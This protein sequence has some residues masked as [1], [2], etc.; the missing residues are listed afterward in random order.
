MAWTQPQ[1]GPQPHAGAALRG[2]VR[3][4]TAVHGAAHAPTQPSGTRLTISPWEASDGSPQGPVV[5]GSVCHTDTICPV[6]K[7]RGQLKL[8]WHSW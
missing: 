8:R 6:L 5:P 4:R 7:S 2:R 1:A 3:Q